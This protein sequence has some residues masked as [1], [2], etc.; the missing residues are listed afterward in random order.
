MQHLL[1][2]A[3]A[4]DVLLLNLLHPHRALLVWRHNM[5]PHP[6]AFLQVIPLRLPAGNGDSL[7]IV[8]KTDEQCSSASRFGLISCAGLTS[9]HV[10]SF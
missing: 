8:V 1:A 10:R 4:H 2:A 3:T 6:P 9:H 7:A 5:Q